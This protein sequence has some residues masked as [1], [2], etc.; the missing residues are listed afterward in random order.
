MAYENDNFIM[1]NQQYDSGILLEE[2][3][4]KYSLASPYIGKNGTVELKWCFRQEK[5]KE[6]KENK[7]G[8]SIPIKLELGT[9]EEAVK[10]LTALLD[11]LDPDGVLRVPF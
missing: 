3:K 9:K 2:Y 7:P 11:L 8:K 5:D 6:S 10:H 4:D 1:V